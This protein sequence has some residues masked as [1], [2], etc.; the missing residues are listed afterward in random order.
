MASMSFGGLFDDPLG[1]GFTDL[2][3]VN[4]GLEVINDLSE[5]VVPFRHITEQV[6]YSTEA[7]AWGPVYEPRVL[8]YECLIRAANDAARR[9][10]VRNLIGLLVSNVD[11]SLRVD[12][13]NDQYWMVRT[14]KPSIPKWYTTEGVKFTLEFLAR[15]GRAFS[16]TEVEE[17]ANLTGTGGT[18]N[19]NAASN[20]PGNTKADP[21]WIFKNMTSGSTGITLLNN[22]TGE[23]V[24]HSLAHSSS[25]WLKFDTRLR[26]AYISTDSGSVWTLSQRYLNY[27]PFPRL[28]PGVQ[29]SITVSGLVDGGD[30]VCTYRGRYL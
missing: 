13:I 21:V 3:G 14:M 24:T 6:P 5:L 12:H 9:T 18:F 19:V 10:Q 7:V 27:G 2:S 23:T 28:S 4:Y 22:T 26:R 1:A 16:T 30:V 17:T 25:T 15:D 29:N 20:V 11:K 8:R